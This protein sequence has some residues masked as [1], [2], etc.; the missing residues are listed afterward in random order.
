[1]I[2]LDALLSRASSLHPIVLQHRLE[3]SSIASSTHLYLPPSMDLD[4]LLADDPTFGLGDLLNEW[5]PEDPQESFI[6]IICCVEIPDAPNHLHKQ[7][8]RP[9]T[10]ASALRS[11][12][13]PYFI[14]LPLPLHSHWLVLAFRSHP[15]PP[16][17]SKPSFGRGLPRRRN[18]RE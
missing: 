18:C 16:R 3:S 4:S 15:T 10:W 12:I 1:M 8:L 9:S 14:A 6:G 17:P 5:H 13:L 7:S 2:R 11:F